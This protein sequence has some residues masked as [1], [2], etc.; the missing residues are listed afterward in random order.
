VQRHAGGQTQTVKQAGSASAKQ[1]QLG[2]QD[3]A[4]KACQ[5]GKGKPERPARKASQSGKGMPARQ[6]KKTSQK[7]KPERQASLAKASKRGKQGRQAGCTWEARP[8][9][10][11]ATTSLIVMMAWMSGKRALL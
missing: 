10:K 2:S 1:G 5:S 11:E 6:A 7:G 9:S 4:R 8:T 3:Q